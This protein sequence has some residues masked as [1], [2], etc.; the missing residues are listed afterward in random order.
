MDAAMPYYVYMVTNRKHGTLYVG[1][2]ND[3][4]RRIHE[5]RARECP[6]FTKRY[7]LDK[8]VFFEVHDGPREAIRREKNIKRWNRAWKDQLIEDDNPD[9]RDLYGEIV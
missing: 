8:L 1:I 7:N 4:I 2:T 5:H 6:G 9:W 3:L